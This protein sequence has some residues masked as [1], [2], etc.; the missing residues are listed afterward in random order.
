M[1]YVINWGCNPFL[2]A[3][4]LKNGATYLLSTVSVCLYVCVCVCGQLKF[5]FKY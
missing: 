5:N 1:S 4:F 2:V 3:P